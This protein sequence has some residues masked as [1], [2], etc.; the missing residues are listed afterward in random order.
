M[1]GAVIAPA[2]RGVP[3]IENISRGQRTAARAAAAAVAS[4][5]DDAAAPLREDADG[6]AT[7]REEEPAVDF[8]STAGS[9]TLPGYA[10]WF[11]KDATHEI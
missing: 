11:R 2:A 9:H 4:V 3:V 5:V 7:S 8:V 1:D 10:A 6:D